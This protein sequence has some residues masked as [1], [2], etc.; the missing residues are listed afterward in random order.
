MFRGRLRPSPAMVVAFIALFVAIGGSSYAVTRLPAKSV[1]AKQIRT[2]AVRTVHIARNAVTGAKIKNGS[3]TRADINVSSLAGVPSAASATNAT[4]AA[5]AAGL[6]RVVQVRQ[7]G[8][9]G[10]ATPNPADPAAPTIA[11]G[12]ASATCPPGLLATGG[13][14]GVDD[15]ANTSVVD[16]FPEPG[17]HAWTARVDNSDVGGAHGFTVVAVCIGA[18]AAG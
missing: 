7:A 12:G 6:D 8:S 18:A 10:A 4:H 16:S 1:G 15:N 13:G 3:I 5:S 17:G 2:G 14:V 11:V 9:V